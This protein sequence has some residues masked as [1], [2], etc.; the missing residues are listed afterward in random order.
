MS[1]P[2]VVTLP[3]GT[4][5]GYIGKTEQGKDIY[6]FEGIPYAKPPVGDSRFEAR[7]TWLT[8]IRLNKV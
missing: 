5:E 6:V 1:S 4:V 2:P 8:F 3:L 7:K